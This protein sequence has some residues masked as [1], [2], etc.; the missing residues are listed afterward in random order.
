MF[1]IITIVVAVIFIDRGNDF[2]L[3]TGQYWS[4]FK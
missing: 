2:Q 4:S 1:E 3:E